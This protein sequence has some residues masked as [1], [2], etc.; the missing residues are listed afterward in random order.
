[1][2]GCD[3]V[4]SPP[5]TPCGQRQVLKPRL[6]APRLTM[7]SVTVCLGALVLTDSPEVCLTNTFSQCG[8]PAR[9]GPLA[10]T[11]FSW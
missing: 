3:A 1:M 9:R 7:A 6:H 5:Q 11:E 2:K 8:I 10:E 4:S